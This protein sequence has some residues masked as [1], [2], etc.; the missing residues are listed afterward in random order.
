MIVKVYFYGYFLIRFKFIY[1]PID[2]FNSNGELE[3]RKP[4]ER[5]NHLPQHSH[6]N[7]E[8]NKHSVSEFC[9]THIQSS[10]LPINST[11]DQDSSI[12]T[13]GICTSKI[14]PKAEIK[15]QSENDLK[16]GIE[17]ENSH[18][19]SASLTE[20]PIVSS[21]GPQSAFLMQPHEFS[22]ADQNVENHFHMK[23]SGDIKCGQ[24][25]DFLRA[26]EGELQTNY[27]LSGSPKECDYSAD[28]FIDNRKEKKTQSQDVQRK[29]AASSSGG[30]CERKCRGRCSVCYPD[31]QSLHLET[32]GNHKPSYSVG[33][34][35]KI[36]LENP[37]LYKDLSDSLEQTF[38]RTN[39]E[40]KVRRSTR[41]QRDL[42]NEGLVW[43]LLPPPST[44]CP[45]Q[46]TKRRTM[47][48][49]DDRGLESMSPRRKAVSRQP[50]CPLYS[51]SDQEHSE[52]LA[53]NSSTFPQR[54]RKSFCTSALANTENTKSKC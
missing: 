35:V 26:T 25:D 50:P 44:S 19:S 18:V 32:D 22:A 14:I 49:F 7:R 40:T 33:S 20:K 37:E 45:S 2:D 12:N 4:P 6:L 36:S 30:N 34:T 42:E 13:V 48:T 5:K 51:T 11:F 21:D 17:N 15:L 38:Q 54:R 39:R 1:I 31:G 46:R 43:I 23:V 28:V 3:E 27:L 24:Q 47:H 53:A 10:L 8:L 29:L 52:G 16:T 9:S 41:L